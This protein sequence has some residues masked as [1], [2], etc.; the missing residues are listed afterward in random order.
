[1]QPVLRVATLM[2]CDPIRALMNLAIRAL[3]QGYLTPDQIEASFA[4]MGLDTQLIKDGTYFTV[5]DGDI[6]VGCGG[7]S[8][9][10]TLHGGDHSAG[11]DLRL[12]DPATER[13]RI[14]AMYT[15][16]D[17]I[18]R[19]IGRLIIEASEAAAHAHGF[20]MLELA[21]T[22]AGKPFYLRCGYVLESEW[23]DCHGAVPVP[24]ATM[25]KQ[26]GLEPI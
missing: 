1:M 4:G 16:P 24:L 22:M 5:W 11:R 8:N 23:D 2:D 19:G 15:H 3:Q 21:A 9:R 17:H 6:L 12:L 14:R 7:W 25:V 26:I 20:R 18:K 10:A 13:A